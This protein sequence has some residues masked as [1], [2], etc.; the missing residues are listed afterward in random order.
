MCLMDTQLR[1]LENSYEQNCCE[2]KNDKH[3]NLNKYK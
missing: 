3:Y 1:T 2:E